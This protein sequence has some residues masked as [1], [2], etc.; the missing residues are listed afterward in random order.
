MQDNHRTLDQIRTTLSTSTHPDRFDI[1]EVLPARRTIPLSRSS[2]VCGWHPVR[3][4]HGSIAFESGLECA[5]IG[6]LGQE[7]DLE[8]VRSQP[9]TVNYRDGERGTRYTPDLFVQFA[10]VPPAFKRLGF[11]LKTFVEVKP[12]ER[13]ASLLD[14]LQ[15]QL[16]V[17][18]AATGHPAVLVTDL[19]LLALK[20]E[21]RRGR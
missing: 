6:L 4:G 15:L 9:I 16:S 1:T 7:P 19:D 18:R 17:V 11:A 8:E 3:P 20:A 2:H 5:L 10:K 14:K 13:A 21:V 12:L